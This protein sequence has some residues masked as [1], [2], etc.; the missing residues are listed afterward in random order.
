MSTCQY[1]GIEFEGK[2]A[3]TRIHPVIRAACNAMQER[4][5]GRYQHLYMSAVDTVLEQA[6]PFGLADI[7]R[8]I[9]QAEQVAAAQEQ[10]SRSFD[11]SDEESAELSRKYDAIYDRPEDD[12]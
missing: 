12:E 8:L 5:A 1:T 6:A 11:I 7:D 10:E 3:W 4:H 2:P 9:A